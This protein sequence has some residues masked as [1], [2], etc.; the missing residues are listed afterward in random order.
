M[1]FVP[2]PMAT[3]VL[4]IVAG[5]SAGLLIPETGMKGVL[6]IK[7][8]CGQIIFFLVPLIILGFVAPSIASLKGSVSRLIVF[9]FLSLI[10]I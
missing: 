5:I 10:H 1:K 3:L 6:F 2:T 7:Q 9:A 4:S 8:I